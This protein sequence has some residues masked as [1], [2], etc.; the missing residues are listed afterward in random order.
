MKFKSVCSEIIPSCLLSPKMTNHFGSKE[1][2]H[3]LSR[4]MFKLQAAH[5][6]KLK[7]K[8]KTVNVLL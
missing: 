2:Q 4:E 7:L 8:E 6:S 1:T 3:S 5:C